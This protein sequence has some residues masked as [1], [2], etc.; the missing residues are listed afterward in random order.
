MKRKKN[1]QSNF[2]DYFTQTQGKDSEI[3][4]IQTQNQVFT[5]VT[6]LGFPLYLTR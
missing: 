2:N 4:E 1:Q 5:D 3:K 6:L